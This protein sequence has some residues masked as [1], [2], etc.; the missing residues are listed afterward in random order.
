MSIQHIKN[1][2]LVEWLKYKDYILARVVLIIFTLLF[3]FGLLYSK[4]VIPNASPPLPSVETFFEFPTVW[5]YQG[6][7]GN[8]LVFIFLGFLLIQMI[9]LEFSSKTMRQS[10]INGYT[11]MDYFLGKSILVLALS[12]FATILFIITTLIFGSWHTS[13]IEMSLVFD[14]NW[15]ILRFF[16]MCIGYLSFA[17]FI[18]FLLRRS[19][20]SVI[21]Y[22]GYIF[23]F[24]F[25]LRM[26]HLYFFKH[27][28]MLFWPTNI[29][30]DLMPNPL[31]KLPGMFMEKEWG[32]DP[33]L[34]Y[35]EALTGS[36]V[37]I[38]LLV[39]GTWKIYRLRDI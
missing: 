29:I 39:Y 30:E 7:V 21:T 26:I 27:R 20:L 3:C 34:S 11:K 25:I 22:F 37:V 13:S 28:S 18:A 36:V 16:L 1:L 10:I 33:M 32:F 4:R 2:A 6:H 35:V 17:G 15:V 23:I 5:D 14:T 9:C 8:W 38:S 31:Y 12:A 24:E 19:G